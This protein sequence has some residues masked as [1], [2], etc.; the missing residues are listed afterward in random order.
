MNGRMHGAPLPREPGRAVALG[1]VIV[2][3][4]NFNDLFIVEILKTEN[5]M[6]KFR[7]LFIQRAACP[8]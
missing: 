5:P 4:P 6:R 1:R 7:F 3:R 2:L 8:I